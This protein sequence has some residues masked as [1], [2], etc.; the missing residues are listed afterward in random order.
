MV[1]EF[2]LTVLKFRGE[3]PVWNH[4]KFEET[5]KEYIKNDKKKEKIKIW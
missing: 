1:W 4:E 3:I 2:S 5:F